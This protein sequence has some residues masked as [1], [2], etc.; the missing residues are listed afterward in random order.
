MIAARKETKMLIDHAGI[1]YT[2]FDE[3]TDRKA[4]YDLKYGIY[5]EAHR[6]W[7]SK[8]PNGSYRLSDL[9]PCEPPEVYVN[10]DGIYLNPESRFQYFVGWD[11]FNR[12]SIDTSLVWWLRHLAEKTWITTY[13]LRGFIYSV[14]DRFGILMDNCPEGS[15]S[16]GGAE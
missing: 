2:L 10:D 4:D 14:Y 1:W 6:D 7:R 13:A 3:G 11:R 5:E 12:R 15:R 16:K 9:P 8:H